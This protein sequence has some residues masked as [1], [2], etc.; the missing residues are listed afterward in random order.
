[1]SGPSRRLVVLGAAAVLAG[2]GTP[3]PKF[4][5]LVA[6]PGLTNDRKLPPANLRRV[7][8]A[9]YLD[10]PQIVRRSS[11]VE[12]K[13]AEFER[14]GEGFDDMATRVLL[15]DLTMRLPG[16]TL[17]VSGSNVAPTSGEAQIAV[18]LARFDP[19]PGG[20][21]VLE[22]RW[23]IDRGGGAQV[24]LHLDRITHDGGDA[25]QSLVSAMSDCLGTLADRIAA[26][27]AG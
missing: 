9:E 19:D 25:T 22:A 20:T 27:Y 13:T 12:L 3:P 8:I 14:W 10:R 1:M 16:T 5:T 4:Y 26:A 6:R 24:P 18:A 15:E 23:S 2:C 21:I 17:A 7:E 11:D